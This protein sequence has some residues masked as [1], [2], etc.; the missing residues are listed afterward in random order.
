M[1]QDEQHSLPTVHKLLTHH[2]GFTYVTIFDLTSW[3]FHFEVDPESRQHHVINTPFG[4][5]CYNHL[6]MGIKV[7]PAFAQAVMTQL[8]KDLNCVEYHAQAIKSSLVSTNVTFS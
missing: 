4:K 6:P 8:Y 1:L 3:F 5:Y 2:T 7:A